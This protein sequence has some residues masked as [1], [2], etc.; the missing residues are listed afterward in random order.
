MTEHTVLRWSDAT[1][2]ESQ[3]NITNV[4]VTNEF[5]EEDINGSP[6]DVTPANLKSGDNA[7]KERPPI[8]DQV[9]EGRRLDSDRFT[10]QQPKKEE[11]ASFQSIRSE[12]AINV[13]LLG[14]V[15]RCLTQELLENKQ[16]STIV[17]NGTS[18]QK[19]QIGKFK[20]M[21]D[22]RPITNNNQATGITY[23]QLPAESA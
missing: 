13:S 5:K 14:P 4:D 17:Q 16:D 19:C 3:E 21:L 9:I 12:I 20:E 23:H 18:N 22:T 1:A 7:P 11:G 8:S 10:M 15:E 6:F 2:T